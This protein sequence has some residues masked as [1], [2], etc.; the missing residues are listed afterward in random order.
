MPNTN[1]AKKAVRSSK[2][3]RTHNLRWKGRVK[4]AAKTL[5]DTLDAKSID[6]DLLDNQLSSL[7][8]VLD[9]ASK[10]KVISKNKAN[11]IKS[12]Y[13]NRITAQVSKLNLWRGKS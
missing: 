13:A 6:K 1:S 9:K 2:K 3:K 8:K 11:R 12:K 10:E 4:L 7:Q 5:R